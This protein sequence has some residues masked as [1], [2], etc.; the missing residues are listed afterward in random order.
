MTQTF[1]NQHK[2]LL[3]LNFIGL[4]E[5][6]NCHLTAQPQTAVQG[7]NLNRNTLINLITLATHK[8]AQHAVGLNTDSHYGDMGTQ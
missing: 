5:H 8:K 1:I 2:I 6:C 3:Q 7:L 4:H